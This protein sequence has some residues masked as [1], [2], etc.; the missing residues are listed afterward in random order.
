MKTNAAIAENEIEHPPLARDALGNLLPIPPGTCAWRI[1]R[2]TE[3]RP[4]EIKGP[5]KKPVR[6]ALTTTVEELVD[7]CGRDVYRIYALDEVGE[8][9]GHITTINAERE[10][11]LRNVGEVDA[12]MFTA[13]RAST[14]STS[15]LRFALEALTQI[16]RI[17]GEALRSVSQAQADWVKAIAMAKG[18]PRNVAFPSP[19]DDDEEDDEDEDEPE[20]VAPAVASEPVSGIDAFLKAVTPMLPQLYAEWRGEKV[21]KASTAMTHLARIQGQLSGK[22]KMF[23]ETLLTDPVHGDEVATWFAS[24]SVE[25]VV[26]RIRSET[27]KVASAPAKP[28]NDQTSASLP[29]APSAD[30]EKQFKEKAIAIA[31]HLDASEQLRL[32]RLAPQLKARIADPEVRKIIDTLLKMP[33]EQAAKWIREHL[34]EIEKRFAS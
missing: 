23:L 15:D 10:H 21:A 20:D 30:I 5:D 9:L 34:A 14:A 7:L 18:L 3:G 28:A 16:A 19:R 32:V 2:E 31:V 17:N 6:F 26:A 13:M 12:T 25:D 8:D 1:C 22:E 33:V 29:V 27:A 4:R 11:E 24:Q